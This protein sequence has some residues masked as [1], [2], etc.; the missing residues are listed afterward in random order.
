M[1]GELQNG[2]K[3]AVKRLSEH[4]TQ[5]LAEFK[6]EVHMIEQLQHR[7]LIKLLGCCI[8]GDERMLVYEY[9]PNK[10][11]DQFIFAEPA[12]K[13]LLPWEKRMS[14]L[15]G[16]AKGLDYLHFGSRTRVIH[17]DLKASNILLDNEMNPIISDF[18]LA[19]NSENEKEETTKRVIGT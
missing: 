9:I 13:S 16:V 7:N 11:L 18:G 17:R 3:I 5:G 1:Q 10:S 12:K 14:I 19:K 8:Q 2:Q 6:N 15:R 4:S